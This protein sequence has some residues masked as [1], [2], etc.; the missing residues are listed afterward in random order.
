MGVVAN[1]FLGM[2]LATASIL[3]EPNWDVEIR[4]QTNTFAYAINST[5]TEP[6][7]HKLDYHI[8]FVA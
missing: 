8:Y 6:R 4:V 3:R 1:W 2:N 5:L 7:E